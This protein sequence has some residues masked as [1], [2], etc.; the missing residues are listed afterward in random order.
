MNESTLARDRQHLLWVCSDQFK[1]IGLVYEQYPEGYDKVLASK[2]CRVF[3][4]VVAEEFVKE[5][6]SNVSSSIGLFLPSL[7]SS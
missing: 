6:G 1:M 4:D 7:T 5:F 3:A 2:N